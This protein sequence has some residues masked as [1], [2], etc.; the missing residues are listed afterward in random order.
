MPS[1]RRPGNRSGPRRTLTRIRNRLWWS[2]RPY[3]AG[4]RAPA[5]NRGPER[6]CR[7]RRTS[8]ARPAVAAPRAGRPAPPIT[9]AARARRGTPRGRRVARPSAAPASGRGTTSSPRE[10]IPR[11][12]CPTRRPAARRGLRR[13]RGVRRCPVRLCGGRPALW[14]VPVRRQ[15]G[16]GS[17]RGGRRAPGS[18]CGARG[19]HVWRRHAAPR[20][21][22]GRGTGRAG[23]RG[24][25]VPVSSSS[26]GPSCV[27]RAPRP[28]VGLPLRDHPSADHRRVR[29]RHAAILRHREGSLHCDGGFHL[30]GGLDRE[31]GV[32]AGRVCPVCR[33][34]GPPAA[35]CRPGGS[36]HAPSPVRLA[37]LVCGLP[38]RD[39]PSADHRRVRVR[40]AA[41]L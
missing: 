14:G 35:A 34:G 28:P 24:A 3:A 22:A 32:S 18:P 6:S 11:D 31:S 21:P 26:R 8:P 2:I 30:E 15:R 17:G 38:L 37:R 4:R 13:R 16:G 5:R 29:V 23:F 19:R 40:H 33:G 36:R 41:I 7:T 12:A 27:T 1:S 10:A 9:G 39:H 25:G 20:S